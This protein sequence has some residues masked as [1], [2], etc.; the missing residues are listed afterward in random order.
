MRLADVAGAVG[1]PVR[2]DAGVSV[3]EVAYDSRSVPAGAV[4]FC[5]PGAAHDGHAFAGAA[6]EA[7]ATAVVVERLL[8]GIAVPQ[9]LVPSVRL[10]I[11]PMSAAVFGHPGRAMTVV[12]V[13]GTNGK[14]TV[15]YLLESIFAGAGWRPGLI[16]TTGARVDREH[17]ALDKTTPEAPDLHRLLAEMRTAG[18]QAIAMEVSSHALDQHRSDGL[19]LD[20]AVFTNLSQDHLDL[21]GSMEA[22]FAAKAR[23]FTPTM[24][25]GAVVNGDDTWG[26]RL[27]GEASIPCRTFA[28]DTAA[29][30][31]ADEVVIDD[32]GARFRIGARRITT[33]MRGRFNVSNALAALAVADGL[34]IDPD[35]ADAAIGGVGL[36]PG[37]MEAIE[38]GQ[39]FLVVV[40]YA[41][42]PDS[43]QHVLRGA[44]PLTAGR[45]IVV[46]GCG[47]DRDRAKRSQMGRAATSRADLT[48]ITSDNPRS[49][50]PS[51]IIAEIERGAREGGGAYTIEA[52]RRRA[53]RAAL[54]EARDG[55]VVVIAGKGHESTQETGGE[56]APFDDRIVAREELAA[57]LGGTS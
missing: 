2:G 23:L 34:G 56:L 19:V 8:D 25:R 24:A 20:L 37:R 29:D 3:R 49:E 38:G 7:G 39:R 46:F 21:H 51:A 33:P 35:Q 4:F 55:D 48:V 12:G 15:T 30:V 26:R 52:D 31:R 18:V 13:T 5:I 53:I 57:L 40:D 22:Y 11:G 16:G 28:L 45:V 6:V 27:L 36:V 47:G 50:D 17:I 10:A 44:R 42:T 9:V 14:T 43:I 1:A 32:R 54:V 41:H